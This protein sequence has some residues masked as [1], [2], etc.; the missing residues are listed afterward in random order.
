VP[1]DVE[2]YSVRVDEISLP[3]VTFTVS[4]SK[5]T[6]IRSSVQKWGRRSVAGVHVGLRRYA[7][8]ASVKRW[9]LPLHRKG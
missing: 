1:R 6:Y 8:A 4:C 3:E 7:A 2:V 5:G 9:P